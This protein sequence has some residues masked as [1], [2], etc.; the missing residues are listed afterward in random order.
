M[1]KHTL[2]PEATLIWIR[3]KLQDKTYMVTWILLSI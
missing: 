3:K 2:E 1:I